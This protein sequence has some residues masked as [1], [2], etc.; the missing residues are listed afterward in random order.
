MNAHLGEDCTI[1]DFCLN[2]F[3][4]P[5]TNAFCDSDKVCKCKEGFLSVGH[6]LCVLPQHYG[7]SCDH[8]NVCK[9]FDE[10]SIC[11]KSRGKVCECRKSY[12]YDKIKGKCI[13]RK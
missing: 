4:M 11:D 13:L 7:G 10:N 9:Y 1:F 3:K 12:Q 2:S 8:D 5:I 6:H